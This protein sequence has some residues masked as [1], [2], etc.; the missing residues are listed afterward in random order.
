M[1]CCNKL[2][3]VDESEET[4]DL[5]C[6]IGNWRPEWLQKYGSAKVFLINFSL[7]AIFQGASFTYLIGSMTT[8]EKRY[9]FES[10]ISGLILIADNLS[11][12][13][14]NPFI[15]YLATKYNRPM[16]MAIGEIVVALACFMSAAPYFIV[17]ANYDILNNR[18]NNTTELCD[19]SRNVSAI[20]EAN[21]KPV[22]KWLAVI[23]L[24]AASFVNGIGYTEL[25]FISE[26]YGSLK[27]IGSSDWFLT[28][29]VDKKREVDESEETDDLS[30][31]IGSW[32]P[33][34]LQ[35]YGSAKVFLINFSLV[36]IFQGASFTYLIGSMT[37]LEKRYGFE[38]KISGLILIADNLSQMIINPFI[39]YLATKYN[40]PM[41][42]AIGEIVVALACFM[43]AELCDTSRNVSAICEANQ[44][45]VTKWLAVIILFAASFV[46]G[47]GYTAFYTIGLPYID[48]N[49]SKKSSPLYL[50]F[51]AALRLLGPAIG[52]LLSQVRHVSYRPSMD[53]LL[54]DGLHNNRCTFNNI[55]DT[56]YDIPVTNANELDFSVQIDRKGHNPKYIEAQ[57]RK[58]ASDANFWTGIISIPTMAVGIFIG[59]FTLSK[60]RPSVR[61]IALF[62]LCISNLTAQCNDKCGCTTRAFQPVCADD[63]K[64]NYFSPCYAGCSQYDPQKSTFGECLCV[65][66]NSPIVT[67]GYCDNNCNKFP[68]YIALLGIAGVIQS[69]SKIGDTLITLRCVETRDKNF[70]MGIIGSFLAVFALIPYPLV[71]GTITD[72]AC[73]VWNTSCG[74]TGNCWLYDIDKYYLHLSAFGLIFIGTLF[75][76]PIIF[77]ANRMS[78]LFEDDD[79]NDI[80]VYELGSVNNGY[81][82]NGSVDSANNNGITVVKIITTLRENERKSSLTD[83]E[84]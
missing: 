80:N 39:G 75:I 5:S 28:L 67:T 27:T 29:V 37:T 4:D 44:K 9:G 65:G 19:T 24:F 64:S 14:I 30:C 83:Y 8:L 79:S 53:R 73:I 47:I 46:N 72:M 71:F 3:E 59:G 61:K 43:S 41:L 56:T 18:S 48:D 76:F 42:M 69:T 81:N 66:G 58:S 52:F 15:G 20:C 11:Q 22:T 6:G 54:V 36:A 82:S 60:V 21:H 62:H 26:F 50:S 68:I 70:A 34:W 1:T 74:K 55:F 2:R 33:E 49:A 57:F 40:R 16:L 7:V 32:R 31:G 38:S 10:K 25:T 63:H 17:E 13:I 77:Y 23:I 45:P 84:L 35:K 78:D 51:T 12:M